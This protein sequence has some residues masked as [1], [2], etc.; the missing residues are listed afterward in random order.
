MP[1]RYDYI[2]WKDEGRWVVHSPSVPGVYGLGRTRAAAKND[3]FEA[4]SLLIEHLKSI[5]EPLPKP[6]PLEL[7]TAE[8]N[9]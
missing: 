6:K 3:F 8:V 1:K 7:G 5:H 9:G 2:A 4:L